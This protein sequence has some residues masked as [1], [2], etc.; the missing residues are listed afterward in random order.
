MLSRSETMLI[1]A[2]ANA[3]ASE[4]HPRVGCALF[5][6]RGVL[7]GHGFNEPKTHPLQAKYALR[8]GRPGRIYLHAEL[9]AILDNRRGV[10]EAPHLAC[11]VRLGK[12][13]ELRASFPCPVCLAALKHVGVKK[14]LYF[15]GNQ[16]ATVT[17]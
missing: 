13:G 6:K 7:C 1:F 8:V 4:M 14:V 17:V 16:M 15:D 12:G 5:D 10:R 11:V 9:A 3:R 2:L